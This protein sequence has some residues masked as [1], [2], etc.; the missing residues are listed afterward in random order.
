[1]PAAPL[2]EACSPWDPGFDAAP[3]FA[4]RDVYVGAWRC[5]GGTLVSHEVARHVELG[6][7][8]HGSHLRQLGRGPR[9][10]VDPTLATLHRAGDELAIH[11][12][13]PAQAATAILVRGA[14]ADA[15]APQLAARYIPVGPALARLH[16]QL[17]AATD[18]LAIEEL[19][20]AAVHLAIAGPAAAPDRGSPAH[21]VLAEDIAH[22]LATRSAERLTLERIADLVGAS[23]FHASRVFRAVTGETIHRRLTRLRVHAALYQLPRAAGLADLA[24]AVGFSSHSH[25]T[26]AFRAEL[27]APPSALRRGAPS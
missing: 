19:A 17:L 5:P 12:T 6:L 4:G 10:V 27:G 11:A 14:L 20:L 13:G 24:L 15:L 16:A 7:L 2:S 3:R 22:L 26:A 8:Q 23:P 1:M 21:R 9:R 18:P 25:L